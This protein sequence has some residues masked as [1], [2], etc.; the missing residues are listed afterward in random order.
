M[1]GWR[2]TFQQPLRGSSRLSKYAFANESID[3]IQVK[4]EEQDNSYPILFRVF[5][6]EKSTKLSDSFFLTDNTDPI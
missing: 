4:N 6:K 5:E 3:S 2:R 1:E